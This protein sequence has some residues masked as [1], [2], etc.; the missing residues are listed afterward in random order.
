MNER[1]VSL[2]PRGD[3]ELTIK[4]KEKA[5]SGGADL[6]GIADAKDFSKYAEKRSPFYY[7][8]KAKSVIVLGLHIFDPL[9]DAWIVSA[10]NS[11]HY[12]VANEIL[13]AI[14]QGLTAMLYNEGKKAVLTTYGGIYTKD[15][16]VL[17]KLGIIGSNNLLLTGKFGSSVR[18]RTI[19]T[20][21]DLVRS[22]NEPENFCANCPKHCW[23]A[24]PA[25]AFAGG[26]FNKELCDGYSDKNVRQ[27]SASTYLYCRI[28]ETA[29]PIGKK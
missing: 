9:L 12:C 14:A 4:L 15:A 6:F 27:L 18:L 1:K 7:L 21:A 28:C 25:K 24:C 2:E 26:Q 13:G 5:A 8:D 10:D 19:V 22:S 3:E 16:A 23:S 20:D 17:A 29:C 11:R